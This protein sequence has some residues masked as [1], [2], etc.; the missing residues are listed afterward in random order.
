MSIQE[1]GTS[2]T[3]LGRANQVRL[4]RGIRLTDVRRHIL[5]LMLEADRPMTAY[6][7]PNSNAVACVANPVKGAGTAGFIVRHAPKRAAHG[8][9]LLGSETTY[10]A[11]K[12]RNKAP[13]SP[14]ARFDE[15]IPNL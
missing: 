6:R 1:N 12:Q 10:A 11:E 14:R 8:R 7:L 9:W 13:A 3:L 2:E 15:Y 4:Q 5:R